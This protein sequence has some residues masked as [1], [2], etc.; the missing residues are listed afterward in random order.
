[1]QKIMQGV[2]I[3]KI[4]KIWKGWKIEL[5]GIFCTIADSVVSL[6][7]WINNANLS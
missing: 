1:M 5:N 7:L 2:A 4:N 6:H 3:L